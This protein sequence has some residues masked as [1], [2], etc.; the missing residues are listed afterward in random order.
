SE[1]WLRTIQNLLHR[2]QFCK[3]RQPQVS[4]RKSVPYSGSFRGRWCCI[5][6]RCAAWCCICKL[7][8]PY[9]FVSVVARLVIDC[10][11]IQ[12]YNIRV[13]FPNVLTIIFQLSSSPFNFPARDC[14]SEAS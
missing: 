5:S 12:K 1:V 13:I 7:S 9:F 8:S 4:E 11:L 14:M 3:A 10:L 2:V 6:G